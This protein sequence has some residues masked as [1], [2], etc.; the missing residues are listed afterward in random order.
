MGFHFYVLDIKDNSSSTNCSVGVMV[1][2]TDF[3]INYSVPVHYVAMPENILISMSHMGGTPPLPT[4]LFITFACSD[5]TLGTSDFIGVA[6][7][8]DG[9]THDIRFACKTAGRHNCSLTSQYNIGQYNVTVS[10]SIL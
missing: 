3:T 4:D 1:V 2:N 9:H 10:L 7:W 5:G 8:D 6:N